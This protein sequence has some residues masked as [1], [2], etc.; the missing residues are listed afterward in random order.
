VAVAQ[1]KSDDTDTCGGAK[2]PLKARLRA[3]WEGYELRPFSAE[4]GQEAVADGVD[5]SDDA[6]AEEKMSPNGVKAVRNWFS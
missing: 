4:D 2:Y 5:A 6:P 1:S 3:W